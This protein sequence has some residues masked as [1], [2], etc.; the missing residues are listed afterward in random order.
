MLKDISY[1]KKKKILNKKIFKNRII[2]S[3][4]SI[5]L[6]KNGYVTKENISF[7]S[8]LAKSGV[9]MVTVGAAAVSEQASDTLNG[10]IVGKIRYL[11]KLKELANSI[12][13]K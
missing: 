10:M 13:K 7:F 4:I 5:N 6:S 3:P 8:N 2:A 12:K 11:K 9:A 1:I